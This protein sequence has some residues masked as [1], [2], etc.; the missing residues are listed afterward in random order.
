MTLPSFIDRLFTLSLT[1][2]AFSLGV[3][4][5]YLSSYDIKPSLSMVWVIV[6]VTL[7]YQALVYFFAHRASKRR[8]PKENT[9]SYLVNIIH[10]AVAMALG[11]VW[12]VWAVVPL[13]VHGLERLPRVATLLQGVAGLVEACVLFAIVGYSVRKRRLLDSKGSISDKLVGQSA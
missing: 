8:E 1:L 4:F 13:R 6:P 10:I 3:G 5:A 12:I 2:N 11:I 9:L 7:V